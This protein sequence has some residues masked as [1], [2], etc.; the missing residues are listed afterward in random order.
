MWSCLLVEM[1]E[2][3]YENHYV[4]KFIQKISESKFTLIHNFLRILHQNCWAQTIFCRIIKTYQID[5]QTD[6]QTDGPN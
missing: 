1:A 5:R 3:V 2:S 6:R 4:Y